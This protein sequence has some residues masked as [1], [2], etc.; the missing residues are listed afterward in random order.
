ML[1]HR[2]PRYAVTVRAAVSAGVKSA[3]VRGWVQRAAP[4]IGLPSGAISV[5]FVGAAVSQRLN[6]RYLR[7]RRPTNILSFGYAPPLDGVIGEL[8]LC[9]TVI[10]AE[11]PGRVYRSRVRFLVEHGLIHLAGLDHQTARQAQHWANIERQLA[12]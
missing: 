7:K 5:A 3:D 1:P 10:R 6:A 9:P 8:I 2:S 11:A 4:L 12:V